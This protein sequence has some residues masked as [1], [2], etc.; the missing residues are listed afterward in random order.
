MH[1]ERPSALPSFP[2]D[3]SLSDKKSKG[4]YVSKLYLIF[5]D[6][7]QIIPT[8]LIVD[9]HYHY[10]YLLSLVVS[11]CTTCLNTTTLYFIHTVYSLFVWFLMPIPMAEPSKAWVWCRSPFEI[12]VSNPA[13][14]LMSVCFECCVLSGRG[15]WDGLVT[16]LEESY[17]VYASLWSHATV[18]SRPSKN[19]LKSSRL[20]MK[21]F[22]YGP[23]YIRINS[24]HSAFWELTELWGTVI[25]LSLKAGRMEVTTDFS[26]PHVYICLF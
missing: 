13:G 25:S 10:T 3:R 22:G 26:K 21:I 1:F 9:S 17:R 2:Y 11:V 16:S 12:T 15:A 6:H 20:R 4:F 24:T 23:Q 14:A 7:C 5:M 8:C 19:R 18:K